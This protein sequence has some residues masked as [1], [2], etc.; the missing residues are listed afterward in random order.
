MGEDAPQAR[1]ATLIRTG[2]RRK[3]SSTQQIANMN[4]G[5]SLGDRIDSDNEISTLERLTVKLGQSR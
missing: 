4:D 1:F 2:A 3:N 5:S